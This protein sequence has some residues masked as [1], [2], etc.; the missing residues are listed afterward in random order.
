[1]RSERGGKCH[2]R[3]TESGQAPGPFVEFIENNLI[4]GSDWFQDIAFEKDHYEA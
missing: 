1:V 4:S 2:G 3:Y